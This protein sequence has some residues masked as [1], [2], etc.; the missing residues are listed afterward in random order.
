MPDEKMLRAAL[1][2]M[3]EELHALVAAKAR[4]LERAER[5][6]AQV[7]ALQASRTLRPEEQR[8][9]EH[10]RAVA[11]AE[12]EGHLLAIIDRLTGKGEK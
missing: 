10:V 8:L 9:V 1:D 6:E 7:A 3:N 11:P 2:D 5:A 4:H 12:R